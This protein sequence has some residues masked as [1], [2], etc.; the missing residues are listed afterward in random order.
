MKKSADLM[1]NTTHHKTIEK[2]IE[3]Q[4]M[5]D[6]IKRDIGADTLNISVTSDAIKFVM[7]KGN[8]YRKYTLD[9]E[10]IS[11]YRLFCLVGK[12]KN[13]LVIS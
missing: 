6:H 5:T 11:K 4:K 3:I 9:N 8:R 10:Y 13:A 7:T 1:L 12:I 2:K